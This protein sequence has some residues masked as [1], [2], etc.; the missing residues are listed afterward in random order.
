MNASVFSGAS[1]A[2]PGRYWNFKE[3]RLFAAKRSSKNRICTLVEKFR[4]Y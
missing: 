2:G 4:R 3:V 1:P